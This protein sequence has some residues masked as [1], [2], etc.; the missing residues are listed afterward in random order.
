MNEILCT[1]KFSLYNCKNLYFNYISNC[2]LQ[3]VYVKCYIGML[4][5]LNQILRACLLVVAINTPL[6]KIFGCVTYLF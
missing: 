5:Y 4:L 6:K 2:C 1:L 3:T